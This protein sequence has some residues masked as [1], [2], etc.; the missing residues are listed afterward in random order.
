[1]TALVV[2]KLGTQP[3]ASLGG[4]QEMQLCRGEK[5]NCDIVTTQTHVIKLYVFE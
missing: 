3:C 2:T 1:M 4:G 5:D